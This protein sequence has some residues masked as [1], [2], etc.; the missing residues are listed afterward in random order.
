M[1]S[2]ISSALRRP[3]TPAQEPNTPIDDRFSSNTVLSTV[4]DRHPNL[5]NFHESTEVPFPSPSPP[6]SP[7]KNGRRGIFKRNPKTFQD[8]E[9]AN[10]LPIKLSIPH[11]KKVKSSLHTMSIIGVVK[12]VDSAL[13]SAGD[14]ASLRRHRSVL[15]IE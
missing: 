12:D 11:L 4:F 8:G 10:T 6:A 14:S 9:H 7:S 3:E 1:W 13:A 15:R 5:S 2:K